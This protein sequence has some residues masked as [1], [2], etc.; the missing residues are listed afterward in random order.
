MNENMS[1]FR[2]L[3]I[4]LNAGIIG[5]SIGGFFLSALYYPHMYVLAG[6]STAAELSFEKSKI[7]MK[8]N[9]H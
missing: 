3:F 2:R 1:S 5:F 7:P 4:C 6:L 8:I 9:D